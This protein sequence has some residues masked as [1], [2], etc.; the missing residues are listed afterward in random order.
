MVHLLK[1]VSTEC[2]PCMLCMISTAVV[3]CLADTVSRSS[4]VGTRAAQLQSAARSLDS[5][6][7]CTVLFMPVL[8]DKFFTQL[9]ASPHGFNVIAD[10]F[11]RGILNVTNQQSDSN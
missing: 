10:F 7:C 11:S 1:H 3:A 5:E 2:A 8:Q 4:C 9:R 6:T